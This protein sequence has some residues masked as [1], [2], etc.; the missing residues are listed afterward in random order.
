METLPKIP[1]YIKL[2]HDSARILQLQEEHGWYFDERA[3]W[4]L[5]STLRKE[6]EEVNQLL[7]DRHPFVEGSVFTPKRPNRT[8]GPG[9]SSTPESPEERKKRT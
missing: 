3:A 2:E 7:R 9:Y 4:E 5:A 6:L 8:Q 1:D